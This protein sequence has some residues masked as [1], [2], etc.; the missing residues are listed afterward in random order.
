MSVIIP[1]IP[2]QNSAANNPPTTSAV[3]VGELALNVVDGTLWTNYTPNGAGTSQTMLQLGGNGYLTLST[4]SATYAPLASPTFTGI[5]VAPTAT[6]GTN[7][8]QI[9]TT[10]FV[11]TAVSVGGSYNPAAVA[12]TGGSIDNTVIGGKTPSSGAYTTLSSS[13]LVTLSNGI[14]RTFATVAAAGTTLATATPLNAYYDNITSGTGGVKLPLSTTGY[15]QVGS[16]IWIFNR[17]GATITVYPDISTNTIELGTAGAG[18][19]MPIGSDVRFTKTTATNWISS[20][21]DLGYFNTLSVSGLALITNGIQRSLSIVAAAGTT[22]ATATALSAYYVDV[23]SGTGGV[24]L[25]LSTTGY[26]QVGSDIWIFNRCGAT[27]IV[28]PDISTNTIELGTAGAGVTVPNGGDTRFTKTTA[29]NWVSSG[30]DAGY[31]TTISSTGLSTLSSLTVSTTSTYTGVATFTVAP[32]LTSTTASTLLSSN[33][34]KQLVS[35]TLSN[36]LVA[37]SG[38]LTINAAAIYPVTQAI[39]T[40]NFTLTT[41]MNNQ[42][43]VCNPTANITVTVPTGLGSQFNAT[44]YNKSIYKISWA[45]GSGMTANVV[46]P[47]GSTGTAG[48]GAVMVIF[49]DTTTTYGIGGAIS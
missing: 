41:A 27:I 1:I 25:P 42:I 21:G 9:A 13:G 16:D 17:C 43:M 20:G 32:V 29:T 10:A 37:G 40:A 2:R 47:A 34:S 14:L 19:V 33:S 11:A 36:G 31:F 46:Y 35:T 22:L 5:P 45:S 8:T 23:T 6:A 30:G 24:K 15:N 38:T 3:K 12:I 48:Q 7:T 44:I 28:Y 49:L 39:Q 18:V 26:N 4:A